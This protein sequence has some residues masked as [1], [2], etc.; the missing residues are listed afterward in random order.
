MHAD[1]AAVTCPSCFESFSIVLPPAEELPTQL[2][3]DCEVCC[4]PMMIY[5]EVDE[6]GEAY[7]EARGLDE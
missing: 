2:D 4:R 1:F 6:E 3:Y 7:A 5:V